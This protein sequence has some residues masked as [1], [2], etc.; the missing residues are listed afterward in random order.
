MRPVLVGAGGLVDPW[1]KQWVPDPEG[2]QPSPNLKDHVA[3]HK[4]LDGLK[5]KKVEHKDFQESV[6]AFKTKTYG[7]KQVKASAKAAAKTVAKQYAKLPAS[8][9]TSLVDVSQK[10]A[11]AFLPPGASIWRANYKGSW[12]VHLK[13]HKR[14]SENWQ[15]HDNNSHAAMLASV[16][17]VWRQWLFDNSM[18]VSQCPVEGLFA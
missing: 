3:L 8:W 13:P 15:I 10:D 5:S 18:D 1:E 16:R 2:N 4:E 12:E 17:F 7:A 9:K 11:K 6:L 14:H